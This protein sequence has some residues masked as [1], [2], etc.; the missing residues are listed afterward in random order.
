MK[1]PE[2]LKRLL[3]NTADSV[4]YPDVFVDNED[5]IKLAE[6]LEFTNVLTKAL[7]GSKLKIIMDSH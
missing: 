3:V 1:Q 2:R 4:N 5:A 6:N 7:Y